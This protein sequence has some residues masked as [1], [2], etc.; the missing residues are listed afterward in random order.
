MEL[1]MVE[2]DQQ[3]KLTSVLEQVKTTSL[4]EKRTIENNEANLNA[5]LD[6]INVFKEK[7]CFETEE[8]NN[9]LPRLEELTWFTQPSEEVLLQLT[10][11]IA[12]IRDLRSNWV[13]KYVKYNRTFS[14][15]GIA[16][17]EIKAFKLMLDDLHEIANDLEDVFFVLPQ[18]EK[19][20]EINQKI[21][22][23]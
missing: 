2:A 14:K 8:I 10:E 19:F 7:L 18:N 9:L 16:T 22:A 12:L 21:A 6:A 3:R 4:K 17:K 13:K 20:Q 11:L 1:L 23:L 5:F 15:K